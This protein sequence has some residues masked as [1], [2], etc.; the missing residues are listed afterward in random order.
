MT[1][2]AR[3][4]IAILFFTTVNILIFTAAVYAA[5]LFPPLLPHAGFWI[6][7]ITAAGMFVTAPIAWFIG[8]CLPSVWNDKLVA[9]PSPLA[10]APTREI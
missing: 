4:Q 9:R 2:A 5:T 7:A 1:S 6:G 3:M 10:H 8:I